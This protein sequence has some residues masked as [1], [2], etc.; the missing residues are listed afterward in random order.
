MPGCTQRAENTDG[1]KRSGKKMPRTDFRS[2]GPPVTNS[3]R[4]LPVFCVASGPVS[5][6]QAP[7]RYHPNN[8]KD[9]DVLSE[10]S[11]VIRNLQRVIPIRRVPL[12][13]NVEIVRNILRVEKFDLGII[14]LDNK[15]IQHINGIYRK[16]NIP[17]DVLSFPF[18]EVWNISSSSAKKRK[19]TMMF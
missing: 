8:F 13:R 10:M 12:R 11:L 3:S 14:F 17:T 6:G 15:N 7:G 5:A 4:R 18:H 16:K 1:T 9:P 19:I 2:T